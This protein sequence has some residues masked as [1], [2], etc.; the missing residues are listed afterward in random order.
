MALSPLLRRELIDAL[1]DAFQSV[2]DLRNMDSSA[3]MSLT[4]A[5]AGIYL[6]ATERRPML[7]R[8][9][10][11]ASS[12]APD[13]SDIRPCLVPCAWCVDGA[14]CSGVR[15]R[16]S[17]GCRAISHHWPG[18]KHPPGTKNQAPTKHDAPGTDQ[19]EV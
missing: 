2:D 16:A 6:Q 19:I 5:P 10:R 8:L 9:T 7:P 18:T 4:S 12:D 1:A 15:T 14:R 11:A 13:T 17:L 3:T